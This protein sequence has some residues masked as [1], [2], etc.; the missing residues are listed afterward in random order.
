MTQER[1]RV[2]LTFNLRRVGV[3][4][5]D[6][7]AEFDA[8]TTIEAIANAIALQGHEVFPLEA[9]RGLPRALS[10]LAPDLVFNVAEGL[11]G[12]NREA[13]VP[14]LCELLGIEF[15]GS[16]A[17]CMAI[18]L[19][20][21]TSK[22]LVAYDGIRTPAFAVL[23][24]GQEALPSDFVYPAIVKPIAEGSSKGILEKQVVESE[25]ELRSI[26]KLLLERYRQPV[27]AEAFL[28][29]REFTI[30]M[31]GERA[32]R[33]LPIMEIVFT[34]RSERFPIYSFASKFESIGVENKVPCDV[35]PEL[36]RELERVAKASFAALGC[37]DIA[38]VDLRLDAEG[39][40]HFIEC[41]PLPGMAPNFSDL[42]VMAKV[43]NL[44]Y[45]SL[46]A[47]IMSP[48]VTRLRSR[49]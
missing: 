40:V 24:S 43:E 1:L 30:A 12:L 18:S 28:P 23:R 33:V 34:D 29:G 35:T 8:P 10:E 39:N 14:A 32:P 47:E 45:D 38:R 20:K 2:G 7:E 13:Q 41:N 25:R 48:A 26:T 9:D 3:S 6:S 37:R 15:T 22:R 19:N 44:S 16:D 31:L 11:Q 46:V 42:C 21:A 27:L 36:Y 5:G 4:E 49:I 17:A